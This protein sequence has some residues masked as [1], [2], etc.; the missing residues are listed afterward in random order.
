MSQDHQNSAEIMAEVGV[1]GSEKPDMD[2]AANQSR[3]G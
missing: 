2:Q 1:I 3:A